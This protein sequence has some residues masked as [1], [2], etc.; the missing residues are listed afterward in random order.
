MSNGR[1]VKSGEMRRF[2]VP[3]EDD[4]FGELFF[5]LD[6]GCISRPSPSAA[7]A[8]VLTTQ[9]PIGFFL[10]QERINTARRGDS[11]M[12]HLRFDHEHGVTR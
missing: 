3:L 12:L 9:F 6:P 1:L 7:P 8:N 4:T 2:G 10:K 11:I 5:Y